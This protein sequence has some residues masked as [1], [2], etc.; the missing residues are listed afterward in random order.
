M[1]FTTDKAEHSSA[2]L[3][4]SPPT[5]SNS[6]TEVAV[7]IAFGLCAVA[8]SALTLWQAHRLWRMFRHHRLLNA[9]AL[10]QNEGTL[11]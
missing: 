11:R 1:P 10:R 4:L 8:A 5:T 3:V 9:R 7:T 2:A 6:S